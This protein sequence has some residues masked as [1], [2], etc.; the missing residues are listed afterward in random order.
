LAKEFGTVDSG[1]LPTEL[2][3][4]FLSNEGRNGG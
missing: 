4:A 1:D 3:Q 2:A